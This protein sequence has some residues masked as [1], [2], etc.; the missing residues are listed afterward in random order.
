MLG[1]TVN[2]YC[3]YFNEMGL[4]HVKE[5]EQGTIDLY[6]YGESTL[7]VAVEYC[8]SLNKSKESN[9]YF[10]FDNSKLQMITHGTWEIDIYPH[11]PCKYTPNEIMLS[12]FILFDEQ[13]LQCDIV[14]H[15][16][17]ENDE[18]YYFTYIHRKT[19][20][21]KD[22]TRD[23]IYCPEFSPRENWGRSLLNPTNNLQRKILS[24]FKREK[25]FYQDNEVGEVILN[26]L[27]WCVSDRK[28]G[29]S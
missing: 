12:Y 27:K 22:K 17:E 6:T 3:P 21:I 18:Q 8:E 15:Y 25:V 4:T 11:V 14:Y 19:G 9:K 5:Q 2:K 1:N 23:I 7:K 13:I 20:E 10:A 28:V 26:Y 24:H 29:R 16:E